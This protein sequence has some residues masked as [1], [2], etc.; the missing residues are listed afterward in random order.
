[1]PNST[2]NRRY[3]GLAA[4]ERHAERRARLLEAGLDLLGEQGWHA[5]TVTAICA[6]AR[7]TPRYFYESFTDRDEFLLAMFDNILA[8]VAHEVAAAL[9][10]E[11]SM[12]DYIRASIAAWVAVVA[13]DRR[14]GRIAFIEALGSEAL[15]RKRLD[16]TRRFAE[17]LWH[18]ARGLYPAAPE[19]MLT[20]ASVAV[21][22]ALIETMIE[23]IGGVGMSTRFG[24]TVP[25]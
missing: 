21:A 6:Q 14:M 1:V 13:T 10:A 19:H 5:T 20:V 8:N 18:R 9:P 7:L 15:M 22:G 17:M 23:W 2:G 4:E 11:P 24:P 16:A 12:Q 25:A 3:G